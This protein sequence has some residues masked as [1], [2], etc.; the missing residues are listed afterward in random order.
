MVTANDKYTFDSLNGNVVATPV[1]KLSVHT[2]PPKKRKEIGCHAGIEKI[3]SI[4]HT[5]CHDI[6]SSVICNADILTHEDISF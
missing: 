1:K 4:G 3:P 6:K 2:E 5:H